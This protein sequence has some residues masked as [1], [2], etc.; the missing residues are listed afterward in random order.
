VVY[1][2]N[3]PKLNNCMVVL[4]VY[5]KTIISAVKQRSIRREARIMRYLTETRCGSRHQQ[6]QS[7]AAT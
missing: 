7:A 5:D 4:K 3:C 2:A 1:A 6:L